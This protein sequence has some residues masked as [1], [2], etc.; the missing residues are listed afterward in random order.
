MEFKLVKVLAKRMVGAALICCVGFNVSALDSVS[1][2]APSAPTE[3]LEALRASSLSVAAKRNGVT[4]PQ[5]ILAAARADYARLVGVLYAQAR[6]GGIV[7]IRVDGREAASIRPLAVPQQIR[8]IQITIDPGP[9]FQFGV[10]KI[11]PLAPGTN[12]PIGFSSGQRA[13]SGVVQDATIVAIKGWRNQGHAKAVIAGQDVRADHRTHRLDASIR[14]SPGTRLRFD[15]LIL[16]GDSAVRD[17]RIQ[18]I[19]DLPSGNLFSPSDVQ[20]VATRL[21]RTGAFRSVSI[22]E[23]EQENPDGT[24][25]ITAQLVDQKPHRFGFGAEISTHEGATISGFWLHR[26][27]FGG[28]ERLRIDGEISGLGGQTG[29]VDLKF[30]ARYERPATF[31]PDMSL[32]F[33]A[34]AERL[35]EPDFLSTQY[36]FGI[37]LHRIFSD[38]LTSEIA[39]EWRQARVEDQFGVRKYDL[40]SLPVSLKWDHRDDLLNPTSGHYLQAEVRPFLGFGDTSSGARVYADARIYKSLSDQLVLAGRLQLGSVYGP[41]V[42]TAPPDYLFYSG[43]GGTVRG[44]TYQSLGIDLGS[45]QRRGGRSFLGISVEARFDLTDTIGIV[46]FAD[47]GYIGSGSFFDNSGKWHSGVGLGLRYD[48][49]IG[50]IRLDVAVPVGGSGKGAQIYIGIGQSF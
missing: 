36:G 49:G 23:A 30:G 24:L 14:V 10:A 7:H 38:E 39:L 1:I 9:V 13:E 32:Y 20:A 31:G 6:Y 16:E 48:T 5:D 44:Q 41:S 2:T 35:D 21:R 37:G 17:R 33:E 46:G 47:T 40:I 4:S 27:L 3:L 15:Q 34:D 18:Q 45:G 42:A 25:D 26:N 43:G 28:A 8:S 22:S 12:L 11:S 29:G 50:P 19:A